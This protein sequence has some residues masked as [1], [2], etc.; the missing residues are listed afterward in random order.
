MNNDPEY[1]IK[2]RRIERLLVAPPKRTV[3]LFEDETGLRLNPGT[4]KT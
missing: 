4:Q 1:D 3:V 2:E